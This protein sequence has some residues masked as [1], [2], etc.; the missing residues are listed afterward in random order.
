[1]GTYG[2]ITYADS[3]GNPIG[4]FT[5]NTNAGPIVMIFENT[6]RLLEIMA[7][8]QRL[9]PQPDYQVAIMRV[10]ADSLAKVVETFKR[11]SPETFFAGDD[12]ESFEFLLTMLRE[13]RPPPRS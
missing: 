1:M 12:D 5:V 8:A 4:P 2:M 9:V 11:E 13:Y 10:K 6:D 3:S 7:Y